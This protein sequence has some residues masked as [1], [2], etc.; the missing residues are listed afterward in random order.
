M[1]F[2]I[3]YYYQAVIRPLLEYASVVQQNNDSSYRLLYSVQKQDSDT[4]LNKP[5]FGP[6]FIIFGTR[7]HNIIFTHYQKQRT[8]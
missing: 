8:S 1:Q 6:I 3:I 7:I 5:N 4:R 2:E